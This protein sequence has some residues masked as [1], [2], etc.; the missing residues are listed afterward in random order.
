MFEQGWS[1][2]REQ[3]RYSPG[4][5]GLWLGGDFAGMSMTGQGG[6]ETIYRSRTFADFEVDE[7][8]QNC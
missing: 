6:V 4:P 8:K 1:Q 5:A 7:N 2:V 3:V